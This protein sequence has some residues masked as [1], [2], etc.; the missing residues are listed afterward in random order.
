MT[1]EKETHLHPWQI[2]LVDAA[3][4]LSWRLE[5]FQELNEV[6]SEAGARRFNDLLVEV[7]SFCDVAHRLRL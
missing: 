3:Q 5:Q 6:S 7:R 1:N 4:A 2:E